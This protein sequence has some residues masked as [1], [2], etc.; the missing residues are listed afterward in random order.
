MV[1]KHQ[2]KNRMIRK[3]INSKIKSKAK[4]KKLL[5]WKPNYKPL[6]RNFKI[7]PNNTPNINQN[8]SQWTPSQSRVL[9]TRLQKI[10]SPP[11]LLKMAS[12]NRKNFPRN[13]QIFGILRCLT[14]KKRKDL[15]I[16][17]SMRTC[18]IKL[19]WNSMRSQRLIRKGLSFLQKLRFL[20]QMW[21][22]GST[23]KVKM[24]LSSKYCP[25]RVSMR[26]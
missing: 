2:N 3:K 23:R 19:S 8:S 21:W 16:E 12:K 24:C 26:R 11:S 10:L 20:Q 15:R 9:L 13:L 17:A 22:G 5:S 7:W 4:I 1:W 6:S 14:S 18:L 25:C